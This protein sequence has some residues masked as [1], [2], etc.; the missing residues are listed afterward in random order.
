LFTPGNSILLEAFLQNSGSQAA[1]FT[2]VVQ[3]QQLGG[4]VAAEFTETVT[5]LAPDAI[6]QFASHWDSTGYPPGE[7]RVI[8]YAIYEAQTSNIKL[9]TLNTRPLLYLPLL[10]H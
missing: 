10:S 9:A 6:Y 8:V 2:A 4:V 3:V 7:Y 5:D 1:S